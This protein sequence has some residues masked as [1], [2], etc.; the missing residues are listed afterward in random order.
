MPTSP[1]VADILRRLSGLR[2]RIRRIVLT[3]LGETHETAG[4]PGAARDAWQQALQILE[5]IDHHNAEQLRNKL[6]A[7]PGTPDEQ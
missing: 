6:A 4:R 1:A 3:H 5:D 2:G 7:M